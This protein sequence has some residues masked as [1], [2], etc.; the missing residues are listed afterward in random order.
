MHGLGWIVR[1]QIN[2]AVFANAGTPKFCIIWME[3]AGENGEKVRYDNLLSTN[4]ETS[5][6]FPYET[7]GGRS[8]GIVRRPS[9]LVGIP[10][11]GLGPQRSHTPS[12][13]GSDATSGRK[14]ISESIARWTEDD[15]LSWLSEA[16]FAEY[17]AS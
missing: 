10:E 11:K 15:V 2:E 5:E 17:E 9:M 6:D 12:S 8:A 7:I 13:C 14:S 16:G 4:A 3:M 1:K